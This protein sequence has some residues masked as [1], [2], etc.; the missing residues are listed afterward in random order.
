ME[1][2][3]KYLFSELQEH[4]QSQSSKNSPQLKL[5][6]KRGMNKKITSTGNDWKFTQ[7][8]HKYQ[9]KIKEDMLSY[10]RDQSNS[11]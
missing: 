10:V 8:C 7:Y 9:R 4:N 5:S 2:I 11:N 3:K 6:K 1:L